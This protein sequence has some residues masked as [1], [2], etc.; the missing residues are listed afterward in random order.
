MF[1]CFEPALLGS[2]VFSHLFLVYVHMLPWIALYKWN[3]FS[4]LL[5][6]SFA[7]SFLSVRDSSY[8]NKRFGGKE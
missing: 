5:T 3:P 8:N 4:A 1:C 6:A 7:Q 2:A